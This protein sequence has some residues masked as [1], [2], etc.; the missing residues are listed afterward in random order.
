M[1]EGRS[2]EDMVALRAAAGEALGAGR[3]EEARAGFEAALEIEESGEA[4]FGL[5]LAL[6]WLRDPVSSVRFQERAFGLF[7]RAGNNEN[8][9]FTA[10]YLCLGY[11][12][13]F[14]NFSASRGW[15]AK[16][17][18]VVEDCG[19]DALRG[20]V[21]LCEAVTLSHEDPTAAEEKA[22]EA[23][24]VAR[25]TSDADLDVCARSE[26]GAALVELGRTREGAALL[27]EAMAGA[28][29]G[30]MQNLDAVV[31]ASCRTITS[32]SRAAD[33][34][35]ATQWIGRRLASTKS[36][37]R[38]T[39]TPRAG[40]TTPACSSSPASGRQA[41]AELSAALSVG[42]LVEP[43]LHA[44][45]L[46]LLGA[47]RVMQGRTGEAER[48]I[49]G[50]EQHAVVVP[51]LAA[52]RAVQGQFE[53]A[54]WLVR[55]RLDLLP[56]NSLTA[57]ELRGLLVELELEH[58]KSQEALTDAEEL[59]VVAT[60][61]GRLGRL[62]T[63]P[64]SAWPGAGC[65]WRRPC[66]T[67]ARTGQADLYRVR[68]ALRSSP[69]QACAGAI[70]THCGQRGSSRGG[71]GSARDVRGT[72]SGSGCRCR[73]SVAQGVGSQ[74][75][76]TGPKR[77]RQ[78]HHPRARDP[79]TARGRFIQPGDRRAALH[80]AEN[81]RTSHRSR[82]DQAGPE[83]P[84]RGGRLRAPPRTAEIGDFP[85]E[86]RSGPADAGAMTNTT[87][88]AVVIGASVAGPAGR[89]RTLRLLRPGD[90]PRARGPPTSWTG[91]QG[92]TSGKAYC[93]PF[94]LVDWPPSNSSCPASRPS[95][96]PAARCVA[97]RCRR[98]GLWRP[99]TRS[100]ATRL[101]P[102]TFSRAARN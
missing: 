41:E 50:Y 38:R 99:D 10:M 94:C 85:D 83:A 100:P 43:E 90:D 76:T 45:A 73:G 70:N 26:L 97:I 35:R 87:N 47:L 37:D 72:G 22:R 25:E 78:S 33:V 44:E 52:I 74:G 49:A 54:E 36:T 51:V 66:R 40:S 55:R 6:W 62:G 79:R 29:S 28:L 5:A 96:S 7:R 12:M 23:L 91:P 1:P 13:T 53:V 93:T 8:A 30:E 42:P 63:E 61:P 60:R 27:D 68:Y 59:L 77:T 75:S 46:A 32:C 65:G 92:G 3:W 16:A 57:A 4:L 67:R 48:L 11:D 14:G 69:L 34:K 24:D 84:R 89:A 80:Y 101:R 21:L 19:L 9:F 18:R 95:S 15:L 102:R 58:G 20:W 71:E 82:T 56:S 81:G 2:T 17:R 98:S 31:L 64:L 88:H 86:R 39:S